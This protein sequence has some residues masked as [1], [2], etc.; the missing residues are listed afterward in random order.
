MLAPIGTRHCETR[1]AICLHVSGRVGLDRVNTRRR[2]HRIGDAAVLAASSFRTPRPGSGLLAAV[3]Q[4]RLA[5]AADLRDALSAARRVRHRAALL[6]SIDDISMGA[7]ALSE[8]DFVRL[9]RRAGIDP[10]IQQAVRRLPSGQRRYLDAQW[11]RPDGRI[12]AVEVDGAIHLSPDRWVADQLRQNEIALDGTVIL[13]FP[14]V[15]VRTNPDEV[16][17]QLRRALR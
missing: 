17:R 12:V 15:V 2:L 8:I 5:T 7:E 16:V 14:S 6:R 3:V 4:Q 13:R 9:C 11:R 10:P 1:V